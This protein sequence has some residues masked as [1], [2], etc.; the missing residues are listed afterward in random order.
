M[1]TGS[2]VR[3]D[4]KNVYLSGPMSGFEDFNFLAFNEAEEILTSEG[5]KVFNP[6]S[7]GWGGG[8][9]ET[10]TLSEEEYRE[11]L[12]KDF[13]AV[14]ESDA[15]FVLPDWEQSR[16]AKREVQV[17]RWCGI[18]VY[19]FTSFAEV[20]E[21]LGVE[22]D[23]LLDRFLSEL[24]KPTGDGANK[25]SKGEKAPWFVD[26]SHES[27]IFSHLTKWKRG[28]YIDPD[29]GAHPL[30]HAAWRCLAIACKESGNVPD[31]A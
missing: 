12:R 30:V 5:F 31:A 13:I 20:P 8:N 15:V 9:P 10:G 19:D 2:K 17:A 14:A 4:I 6:A 3:S 28:E 29:S 7:H 16:G 26:N 1:T 22:Q 18:P 27:A 21:W 11:F 25:R 24:R 23:D